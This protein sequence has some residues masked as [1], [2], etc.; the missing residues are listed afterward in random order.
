MVSG[1][2]YAWTGLERQQSDLVYEP[3]RFLCLAQTT[4]SLCPQSACGQA[5]GAMIG[6]PLHLQLLT[7]ELLL[8]RLCLQTQLL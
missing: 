5:L 4:W 3:V 7:L 2:A 6:A 8:S 1:L